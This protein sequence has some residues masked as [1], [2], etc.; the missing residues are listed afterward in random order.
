MR[1]R[2][3]PRNPSSPGERKTPLALSSYAGPMARILITGMSGAGKSTLLG[4]L[5]RRGHRTVD[6][7][8]GGWKLSN[9]LWDEERMTRLLEESENIIVDGT[10]ENQGRFYDRFDHIVL[11]S[12]PVDVLIDR[13]KTRTNNSYGKTAVEQAEVRRYVVE[14][15]PLLR[16]GATVGLD[17]RRSIAELA[18]LVESLTDR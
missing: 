1:H 13:L 4:E 8:T 10:V 14:V 12:A 16:S 3:A 15:E 18:D 2:A 11:L 9:E 7:D 17:G 6:T 5:A